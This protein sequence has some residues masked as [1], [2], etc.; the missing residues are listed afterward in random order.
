MN[1]LFGKI[2]K[3]GKAFMLP[4]AVLPIA[5]LF[6]RLGAPD[7]LD[8]PFIFSMGQAIFDNLAMLFAIGIAVGLAKEN[9]G[10]AALA[11][12]VSFYTLTYGAKAINSTI[13]MKVLAG[14]IA[15]LIAGYSYNKFHKTKLPDWLGF[16]G[17]KRF[18]PIMASLITMVLALVFGFIWPP[19]QSAIDGVGNWMINAGAP[20]VFAFGTLNRLLI[21]AGLHHILNNIVWF[22]F[23]DF[24]GATG[25]LGRFFAGDPS[26]GI[27]MTGFYPIMMFALPAAALAMLTTAKKEY[28]TT[29][30]GALF[31]VAFTAFLTGITEPLEFMFMFLAPVLYIFHALM[32][33][34][35]MAV[36]YLLDIKSG[37]G[38][39]A[40]FIDYLLSF[41]AATRPL[42]LLPIGAVFGLLYYLVF[43]VA[44]RKMN[45]PTPGRVDE[46]GTGKG[47]KIISDKG[48]EGLAADYIMALGG[49]GNIEDLDCCITRLRLTLK[50]ASIVSDQELKMLGASGVIRPT[51]RNV[52]VI[53]GTKAE[54]IVDEMKRIV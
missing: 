38:F 25:D 1:N 48:L 4:I 41:K 15:G 26:A 17:G 21:P 43:V 19:V 22:V 45:L 5:S 24:N 11:G 23:G 20:G 28:R 49:A 27:F 2:Q 37:F 31:S 8:I 16:F 33:G 47:E 42:L 18:V 52:Q 13:D 14:I 53:V 46:S 36:C 40:G 39:S 54:L 29:V 35:S 9:N 30:A 50:D 44:I 6:L 3:V 32:T 34:L 51:K 10:A 12:A 7:I